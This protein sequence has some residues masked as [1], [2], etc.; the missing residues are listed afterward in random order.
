VYLAHPGWFDCPGSQG[1][2]ASTFSPGLP[3]RA[4]EKCHSSWNCDALT[5]LPTPVG[6]NVADF[7]DIAM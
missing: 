4:L 2:I 1:L 5:R 6:Y 3:D 7:A